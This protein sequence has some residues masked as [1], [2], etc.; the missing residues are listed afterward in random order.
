MGA[1]MTKADEDVELTATRPPFL[2]SILWTV[3]VAAQT[4]TKIRQKIHASCAQTTAPHA[5]QP[6]MNR[7]LTALVVDNRTWL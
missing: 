7:R 2:I 4:S 5:N 1:I 3:L 6:L